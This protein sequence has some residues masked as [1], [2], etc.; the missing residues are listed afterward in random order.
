MISDR[1]A[2]SVLKN[3][4]LPVSIDVV[5][6][7]QLLSFFDV[8]FGK[9]AH[10]HTLA[11]NPFGNIAIW[12]AGMIQKSGLASS[13]RSIDVLCD[14]DCRQRA[15]ATR[16]AQFLYLFFLQHHKIEMLNPFFR[17]IFDPFAKCRL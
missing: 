12:I 7:S 11:N 6:E 3:G 8:A 15:H 17:V 1:L 5:I 10:P 4:Y 16:N 14:P 13:F 9:N 2:M